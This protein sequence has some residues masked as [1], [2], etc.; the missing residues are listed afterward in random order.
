MKN[1]VTQEYCDDFA[2]EVLTI[3]GN[4]VIDYCKQ[5]QKEEADSSKNLESPI[6]F[7]LDEVILRIQQSP[8]RIKK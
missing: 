4:G 7:V 6:I 8:F 3:Y 2:R 1:L 5:L